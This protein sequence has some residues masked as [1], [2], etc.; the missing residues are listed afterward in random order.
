MAVAV[1]LRC[2]CFKH[3]PFNPCPS[4][5]F[6]PDDDETLTKHLLVT[7]HFLSR[8]ELQKIS[9]RV[10]AGEVVEFPPEV[11]QEVRVKKEHLEASLRRLRRGCTLGCLAIVAIGVYVVVNWFWRP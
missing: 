11:L 7:D 4:C 2:G 3:G 5:R 8:E 9:E 6:T 1:C 10:K